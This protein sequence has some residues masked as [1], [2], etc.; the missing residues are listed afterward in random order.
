MHVIKRERTRE[1][2]IEGEEKT[3]RERAQRNEKE[4]VTEVSEHS[5]D[6]VA[7]ARELQNLR[8]I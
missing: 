8:R 3:G 7:G 4:Q 5:L 6:V 1:T 2:V